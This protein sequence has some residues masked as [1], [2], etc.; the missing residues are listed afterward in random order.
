MS[1][2]LLTVFRIQDSGVRDEDDFYPEHFPEVEVSREPISIAVELGADLA[3]PKDKETADGLLY[4]VDDL[5][6]IIV[7]LEEL[8]AQIGNSP[9]AALIA[10]ILEVFQEGRN[11]RLPCLL[12]V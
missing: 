1:G 5:P 11:Y 10:S 7:G 4:E 3:L 12:Q 6:S 9:S 8:L 2:M